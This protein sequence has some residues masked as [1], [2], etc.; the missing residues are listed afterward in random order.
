MESPLT[1]DFMSLR[2]RHDRSNPINGRRLLRRSF[3]SPRNDSMDLGFPFRYYLVIKKFSLHVDCQKI[4]THQ[5][6]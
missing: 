4:I 3:L 6:F 1:M 2:G 5:P